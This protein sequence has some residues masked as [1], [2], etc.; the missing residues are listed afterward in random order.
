MP[1]ARWLAARLPLCVLLAL[2]A[3]LAAATAGVRRVATAEDVAE[4]LG[5]MS[6]GS[7]AAD[8]FAW[9]P[10]GG[11][12][13][14]AVVGRGVLFAVADPRGGVEL[15]R[16]RVRA[17]R[18]GRL[19]RVTLLRSRDAHRHLGAALRGPRAT[20]E[21]WLLLGAD[22]ARS[23]AGRRADALLDRVE[24]AL[25]RW[26]L[27]TAIAA[28]SEA[29]PPGLERLRVHE[30]G[31]A[32][33]LVFVDARRL[34]V[35]SA[36]RPEA[37]RSLA[38][39]L[40]QETAPLAPDV[41]ALLFVAEPRAPVAPPNA[42]EPAH[43][44]ALDGVGRV[45]VGPA[46]P[47]TRLV[48]PLPPLG[49]TA[50]EGAAARVARSA[51][52]V[53]STGALVFAW[54]DRVDEAT[55][56][57]VLAAQGCAEA[58]SLGAGRASAGFALVEAGEL[59]PL[60]TGMTLGGDGLDGPLRPWAI[61]ARAASPPSAAGLAWRVDEGTQP[62]P[63]PAIHVTRRE[64]LGADVSL[65][66]FAPARLRWALRTGRGERAARTAFAPL[67][68]AEHARALVAIGLGTARGTGVDARGLTVAGRLVLPMH[69]GAGVLAVDGRG[70]LAIG[71][72]PEGL[73]A[74][75]GATE[76]AVLAEAGELRPEARSL[77]ERRPRA[78]ACLLED[79]TFVV[80][81]SDFDSAEPNATELR[82]AGC[83]RVVALDR[84]R[85]RAAFV[86][87]A[88]TATPPAPSYAETALYGF[89]D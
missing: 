43:G 27:P 79:G 69:A 85:Q 57:G 68:A 67:G 12:L 86:H 82:A 2:A 59:R 30:A 83:R 81:L 39:A 23:L 8:G 62:P 63:T 21:R 70:D 29:L 80:A 87:R 50:T 13:V 17:G 58:V 61:A 47:G 53:A 89:D 52:C 24:G 16:A 42:A 25:R 14:D 19:G 10:S 18:D 38:E 35:R 49:R 74:R 60:A 55:L 64:R 76:L 33:E 22:A 26:L 73:V 36:A 51:L 28:P 5:A 6:G 77:D 41:R 4:L 65:Y 71:L 56:G 84:G 20:R 31:A 78:A 72:A 1:A 32:V 40:A 66:T 45:H 75:E 44:V 37:P 54:S 88:G 34:A 9:E 3:A 11:W 7:V 48:V 15:H 46:P